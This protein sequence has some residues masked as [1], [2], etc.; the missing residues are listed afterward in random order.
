[1]PQR[2]VER[3]LAHL[4]DKPVIHDARDRYMR[5]Q[6]VVAGGSHHDVEFLQVYRLQHAHLTGVAEAPVRGRDGVDLDVLGV[7]VDQRH[8]VPV[9]HK[10]AGN[11]A[12][13]RARSGDSYFHGRRSSSS[14]RSASSPARFMCAAP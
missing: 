14:L 1:M 10:F 6:L 3:V 4:A 7:S 8:V 2:P 9:F 11:R 13:D 5:R 12:T